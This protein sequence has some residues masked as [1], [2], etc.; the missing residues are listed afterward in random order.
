MKYV[1]GLMLFLLG[2]VLLAG[3]LGFLQGVSGQDLAVFWP[4]LL[5]VFGVALMVKKSRFAAVI[6][7]VT[8]LIVFVGVIAAI[9]LVPPAQRKTL[10]APHFQIQ[11]Q[12]RGGVPQYEIRGDAMDLFRSY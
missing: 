10:K 3:N 11:M 1:I 8:V 12:D 7:V 5:V 4:A 6:N 2:A 9:V